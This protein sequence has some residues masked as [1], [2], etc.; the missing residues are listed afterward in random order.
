MFEL[1]I[2]EMLNNVEKYWYFWILLG[3]GLI[4]GIGGCV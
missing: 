1:W 2:R 3:L 4:A